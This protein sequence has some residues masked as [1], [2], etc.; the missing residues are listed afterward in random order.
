VLF[1][2]FLTILLLYSHHLPW[3]VFSL[4]WFLSGDLK[5]NRVSH[6]I[7]DETAI[8]EVESQ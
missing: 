1:F 4:L 8:Y 2:A 7:T 5:T 6:N 3:G